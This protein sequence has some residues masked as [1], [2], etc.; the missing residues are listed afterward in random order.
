MR[1][2]VIAFV[3]SALVFALVAAGPLYGYTV[4]V[5]FSPGTLQ[6][7]S[8]IATYST[9]GDMMDGM[10][11]TAYFTNSTSETVFWADTGAGAGAATGT[12]W[13]LSESGDTWTGN[14][15]LSAQE[16]VAIR[17]LVIDAGTGDTVFD[18]DWSGAGTPGS[19]AGST[20]NV[21]NASDPL[22]MVVTYSDL[23]RLNGNPPVGDLYREMEILFQNASGFTANDSLVYEADTDNL[24]ISGDITPIPEPA[25][26]VLLGVGLAG[27]ALK[28]RRRA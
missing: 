21:V 6:T 25:T 16:T 26:L 4:A 17:S 23:V 2:P 5:Q 12:N 3:L 15:T 7:T 9:Y 18:R 1:K 22:D 13:S 14:W 10:T 11:V 20:F 8:G 28:R 19:A 27:A 24:E